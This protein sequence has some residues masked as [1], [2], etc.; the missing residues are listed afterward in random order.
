ML[1]SSECAVHQVPRCPEIL[2]DDVIAQCRLCT[3]ATQIG[4]HIV[5]AGTFVYVL[6]HALHNS[7]RYWK[8]PDQFTP[9]RWTE[10]STDNPSFLETFSHN[11]GSGHADSQSS[12]FEQKQKVAKRFLPFSDGP[13]SCVA[14]VLP[15]DW[16]LILEEF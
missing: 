9:D 4:Q 14:Q 12:V 1:K 16:A 2:H 8:N 15:S 6:F 10:K 7:G 5:P 13:R 11:D 3:Q